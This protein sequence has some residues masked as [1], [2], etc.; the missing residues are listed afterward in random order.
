[1]ESF[2][3]VYA[4]AGFVFGIFIP[5]ISRRFA[6]FMPA[7]MAYAL[8]RIVCPGK[9]VSAEK[10][11]NNWHYAKMISQYRWRGVMW[12]ILTAALSYGV[13]YEWGS[14]LIWWKLVFI[15]ILLLLAEIDIRMLL[16]PDIL[17]VPLLLL[18]F[19]F[20]AFSG[21]WAMPY[22]SALGALFGY[23]VPVLISLFFV[24]K[25]KDA[26][27][28]GDVKLLAAVGAWFGVEKLLY[29]II[30]AC[31]LFALYA[32]I[33][34]KRQGAFGPALSAAAIAVAFYYF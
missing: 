32:V 25:N 33:M 19:T 28:G 9:K 16:L 27:G 3:M 10:R 22:D 34:R 20:S 7:T 24:W 21:L 15:W 17:T 31:V 13:F 12:G 23:F 2:Q 8:Y 11:R 14:P 26:F 5:Y 29:A 18:G 1:M 6:K 30:G 4:L